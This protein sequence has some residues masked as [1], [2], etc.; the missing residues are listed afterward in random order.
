MKKSILITACVAL[1]MSSCANQFNQVYKSQDNNL[2][3]EFAKQYYAAGKYS[4]AATLLND[5]I[6]TKKGTQEAEESLYMLAMAEFNMK[7]YE[8]A[9]EYFR[10]YYS[11]YPK[12]LYAERA[13]FF[14]GYVM[15]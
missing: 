12:G 3:Y 5:L 10:K 11:S 9:A 7:D 4:R 15:G 8:T 14:V 2:K 1:L 13:K 6:T